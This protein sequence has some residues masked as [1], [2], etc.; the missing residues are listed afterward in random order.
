MR[1]R[2]TGATLAV[3]AFMGGPGT[4]MAGAAAAD[5]RVVAGPGGASLGYLTPV[6]VVAKGK[7]ASFLNL[8]IANHDVVSV[9]RGG[10]GAPLF[11]S[12][13]VGLG[14][15]SSIVGVKTLAPGIY[16]FFCSLHTNM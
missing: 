16:P 13:L 1:W 15:R 6:T 11:K 3:A 14:K 7:T 2:S 12:A 5:I 4:G 8:D 9:K 10:N